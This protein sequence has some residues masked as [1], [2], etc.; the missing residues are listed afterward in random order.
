MFRSLTLGVSRR[1]SSAHIGPQDRLTLSA[2]DTSPD[3]H[4][5][6]AVETEDRHKDS[7]SLETALISEHFVRFPL[8]AMEFSVSFRT[9]GLVEP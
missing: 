2:Y 3:Y 7:W 9:V 6:K 8:A 1:D 5:A 4:E